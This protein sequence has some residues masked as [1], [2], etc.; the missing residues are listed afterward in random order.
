MITKNHP[1]RTIYRAV[2]CVF[3]YGISV[4]ILVVIAGC[5]GGSAESNPAP[6]FDPSSAKFAPCPDS[7][8]CVSTDDDDAK[9]A[10]EPYPY[11]GSASEAKAKLLE[12]IAAMPRSTIRQA[13]N[14][15]IHVE[16]RSRVFRFVDDVEFFIDDAAKQIRFRSAARLGYSDLGVNRKRMEEIRQKFAESS[17]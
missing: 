8:N 6:T 11:S 17:R 2:Q 14:S 7:P 9:H 16:F 15:Y 10:I 4:V 12:V 5:A 1:C 3:I 13:Q